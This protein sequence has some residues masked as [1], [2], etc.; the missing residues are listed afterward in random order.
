[1]V[2]DSARF[3]LLNCSLRVIERVRRPKA[4]YIT[5]AFSLFQFVKWKTHF[6]VSKKKVIKY[7]HIHQCHDQMH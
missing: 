2:C 3:N 4:S 6:I 5:D 7:I 1:M